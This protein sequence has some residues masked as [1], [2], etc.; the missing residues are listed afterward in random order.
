MSPDRWNVIAYSCV[1]GEW[2]WEPRWSSAMAMRGSDDN[3]LVVMH[4]RAERGW[5]LV[6]R[7]AGPAWRRM[8]QRARAGR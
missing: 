4:R 1:P 7:T 2:A 3:T 5:E 6:A 8:Q